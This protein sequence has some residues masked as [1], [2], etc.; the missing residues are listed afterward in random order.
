MWSLKLSGGVQFG[1]YQAERLTCVFLVL[2]MRMERCFL[3]VHQ[4]SAPVMGGGG[5]LLPGDGPSLRY[6]LWS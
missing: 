5:A 1:P 2:S 4:M 6:F 3:D